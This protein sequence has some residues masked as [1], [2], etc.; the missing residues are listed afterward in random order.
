LGQGTPQPIIDA[1]ALDRVM[2]I[3]EPDGAQIHLE[4]L[5]LRGGDARNPADGPGGGVVIESD[6][7]LSIAHSLITENIASN[8]GA[9]QFGRNAELSLVGVR[10]QNNQ[11]TDL[12]GGIS[13]SGRA[14]IRLSIISGNQAGQPD[15]TGSKLGGGL[16]AGGD[17][18]IVIE[19][20]TIAENTALGAGGG[21]ASVDVG[22]NLSLV[23]STVSGNRAPVAGGIE[24]EE[25]ILLQHITI[26]HN[27]GG[28]I[29]V[30]DPN[31]TVTL[32]NSIVANNAGQN[33]SFAAPNHLLVGDRNL[34]S[35]S[36]CA[37]VEPGLNLLNT[38]PLLGPLNFNHGQTP[39]H[40]LLPG[41]PAIDGGNNSNCTSVDQRGVARPQ[42]PRCDI[43]AFEVQ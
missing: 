25:S 15:G 14:T 16:F 31:A 37:F 11:A 7:H 38:A 17:K 29:Q 28:G 39:S 4:N 10:V 2:H 21:I 19:Q 36:S 24:V 32:L 13:A 23:N 26:A 41:S 30:N 12:G 20:S 18:P 9:I 3:G 34:S 8:G 27:S 43:G 1:A 40:E 22:T 42:G 5:T 35:D 6:S 33:C